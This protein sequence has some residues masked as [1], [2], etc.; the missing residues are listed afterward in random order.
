MIRIHKGQFSKRRCNQKGD[1]RSPGRVGLGIG[2]GLCERSGLA[3][4]QKVSNRCP[5]WA[6]DGGRTTMGPRHIWLYRPV[7]WGRNLPWPEPG[8]QEQ[9]CVGVRH[10]EDR[11]LCGCG[12]AVAPMWVFPHTYL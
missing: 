6:R 7:A 9:G 10:L 12:V 4:L 2:R 8:G 11:V 1:G 3:N 5:P